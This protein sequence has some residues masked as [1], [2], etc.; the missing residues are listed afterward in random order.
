MYSI[1]YIES[2]ISKEK[3]NLLILRIIKIANFFVHA[4]I[5]ALLVLSFMTYEKVIE[6]NDRINTIKGTVLQKRAKD[7]V[8]QIEKEWDFYYYRLKAIKEMQDKSSKYAY[9]IKDLGT[10]MPEGDKILSVSFNSDKTGISMELVPDEKILKKLSSFYDYSEILNEAFE[11]SKYMKKEFTV[12][13][14]KE[15]KVQGKNVS[16]LNLKI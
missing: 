13:N 16:I 6:F 7:K 9:M 12:K 2:L 15:D 3:Y 4:A 14:L 11:E 10:Y 8:P 1:N 5:I